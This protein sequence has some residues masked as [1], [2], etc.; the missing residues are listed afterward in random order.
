M[1][2][3]VHLVPRGLGARL[4]LAFAAVAIGTAVA[5]AIAAPPIVGRGFAAMQAAQGPSSIATN[6]APTA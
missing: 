3:A 2:R 6:T 4:A 1:T 5:V